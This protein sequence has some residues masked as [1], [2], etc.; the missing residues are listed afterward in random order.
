M[1][2]RC[3]IGLGN[4]GSQYAPTRHNVGAWFVD[5]LADQNRVSLRQEKSFRGAMGEFV[6][7]NIKCCLFKPSTYMNESGLAVSAIVKFYK[8]APK[9]MLIAHDELDFETGIAR[10]KKGGG[11]GGH[12]GLR[13]IIAHLNS[14]D[15]YR[16]RIGI[17]HPGHRDQVTPF[18]LGAPSHK[19]RE[20]ILTAL[21]NAA[22]VIPG[23]LLGQFEKAMQELHT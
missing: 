1:S 4:P 20:M 21:D 15:F 8:L 19:D 9:E 14:N 22:R 2:I 16:L 23:L 10:L 7:S 5:L 12:N 18:V 3:I 6:D 13:D 17:G 11:H